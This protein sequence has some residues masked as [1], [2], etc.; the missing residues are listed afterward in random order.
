MKK[1]FRVIISAVLVLALIA[2]CASTSTEAVNVKS[3]VEKA[4]DY[5]FSMYNKGREATATASDYSVVG[6]VAISGVTYSVDWTSDASEGVVISEMDSVTKKVTVDVDE[7]TPEQIDYTLTATVSDAEGNT[8]TASFNYYV[9]AF[10]E[11]TWAEYI[12][13]ADDSTVVVKGKVTGIISKSRDASYNCIYFEDADGGYYAYST[14]NDPVSEGVEVGMTIRVT[15]TKDLYSGTHEIKSGAVEILD[16]ASGEVAATDLTAAYDSASSLKDSALTVGQSM[17]VTIKDV[18]VGGEDTSNGYYYFEK[19]GLKSYV[20]ISSS[21]CPLNKADQAVFK[22]EH[23]SHLGWTADVTGIISLYDG[24]FYLTPV[25]VDSF[26]YKSLPKKSDSEMIDFEISNIS[27]A[28]SFAEDSVFTVPLSGSSYDCVTFAW[29]SDSDAVVIDGSS[30]TVTLQ[31]EETVAHLNAVITSGSE[32]REV[33]YTLSLDAA[34]QDSYIAGTVSEVADGD[35]FKFGL[36]QANTG[37]QIYFAGAMSGEKYLATTIKAD[38]AVDVTVEAQDGGFYLS[39]TLDEVKK[40]ISVVGGKAAITDEAS[41]LWTINSETSVPVTTVDGTDYYLGCYKTYETLS[42]SKTSYILDDTSKIGVSQFPATLEKV[43]VATLKLEK[44]TEVSEDK[45]YVLAV[46]Q[47]NAGKDFVFAGE[48]SGSKYYKTSSYLK[49]AIIKIELCDGG[50]R[51]YFDNDG[52]KT[53]LEVVDG[54]ASLAAE[55]TTVWTLD[56][57][58]SVPVT[59]IG[60]TQYYFGCYKTFETISASKTSYIFNDKSVIGVSQFPAYL[61]EYELEGVELERSA[62]ID[63][64]AT[65]VVAL[66]QKLAGKDLYFAGAMSGEKY[67]ATTTSLSKSVNVYLEEA[68]DGFRMY[69]IADGTK[70]YIEVV[71]G[72]AAL[73]TEPTCIWKMEADAATPYT[74]VDGTDYYLGTYKT[75]E[76]I[77]ASKTSYILSDNLSKIDESQFP[78]MLIEKSAL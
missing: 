67:L 55:P 2:S 14:A 52:T 75:F 49:G 6:V 35:V 11:S 54:K 70:T 65:Y 16:S 62:E 1:G 60:D 63:L 29:T 9:P 13:A 23:A 39:F 66:T 10:K 58:T 24:A 12:A 47:K 8:A 74:N 37:H 7:K 18:T 51:M 5:I 4:R 22:S 76:T 78:I 17:L 69:F 33:E 41:N 20:R 61:V 68:E 34:A 31:D 42:C 50:F 26:E 40:Y 21:T 48:M 27:F 25:T 53:Y 73:S 72:K 57:E 56:A 32:T 71:G 59:T 28:L 43:E 15:G 3:G 45:N 19:N 64:S 44:A 30:V 38:E 77:S 36:Y 46:S